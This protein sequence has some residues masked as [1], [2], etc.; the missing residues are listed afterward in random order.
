MFRQGMI[1]LYNSQSLDFNNNQVFSEHGG[2]RGEPEG[3]VGIATLRG[4]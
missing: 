4:K 2:E 3:S 1:F